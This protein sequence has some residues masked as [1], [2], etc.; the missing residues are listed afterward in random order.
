MNRIEYMHLMNIPDSDFDTDKKIL[1]HPMF[2]MIGEK[3]DLPS[4]IHT[5]MNLLRAFPNI[6]FKNYKKVANDYD[7]NIS[8][9]KSKEPLVVFCRRE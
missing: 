5:S 9:A 6:V 4:K 7:Q 2:L 3:L 1:F 8:F